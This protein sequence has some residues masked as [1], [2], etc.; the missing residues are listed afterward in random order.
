MSDLARLGPIE[1]RIPPDPSLSRVLRL[2]ASGMASLAGFS[3]EQIEDIK[4]AVSEVFLALIEHG[5]GAPVE[6]QFTI[7]N[8]SFD[9]RGRTKVEH[10]DLEHPDLR[11]CRIVLAEASS[12]HGIDVV[13][14]HAC[15]WA[16]VGHATSG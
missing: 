16:T 14:H 10:F 7:E 6:I 4:I 15:I 1:I 5:N 11:L 12:N 3:V 9:L 8:R 2:A 13:D